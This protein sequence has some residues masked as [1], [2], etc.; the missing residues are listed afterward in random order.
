MDL[1][2]DPA[3]NRFYILRQDKNQV[4]VFAGATYKQ[5][6]TLRTGNTPTQ[7]ALTLDRQ[8]LLVGNDD[9]Q[10][11]NVYDLDRLEQLEPVAFPP[12]HYPRSIASSAVEAAYGDRPQ[13]MRYNTPPSAKTSVRSSSVQCSRFACSGAM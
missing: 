11:A 5:I 13:R 6:G 10:L 8:Y 2:A 7:M 9:S 12:G 3:R 1:L 4:L